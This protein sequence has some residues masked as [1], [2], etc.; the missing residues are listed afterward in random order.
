MKPAWRR[1]G[2]GEFTAAIAAFEKAKQIR[3]DDAAS[4]GHDRALQAADREP[5][6]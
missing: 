2:Q 3:K 6:G 5:C 1:G 4:I